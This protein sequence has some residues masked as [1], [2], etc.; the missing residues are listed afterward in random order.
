MP[1][2][3]PHEP[4]VA[5]W[6]VSSPPP[7][8]SRRTRKEAER[9]WRLPISPDIAREIDDAFGYLPLYDK[10]TYRPQSPGPCRSHIYDWGDY[11]PGW[12]VAGWR[13]SSGHK[14]PRARDWRSFASKRIA[15]AA[16]RLAIVD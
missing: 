13:K 15:P 7:V 12:I 8:G 11:T 6:E 3:G 2:L 16:S 4:K 1:G 5:F 9:Q 14:S 10:P